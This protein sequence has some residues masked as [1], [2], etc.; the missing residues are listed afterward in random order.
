[1]EPYV[2]VDEVVVDPLMYA[3]GDGV[4]DAGEAVGGDLT[5]TTFCVLTFGEI[6]PPDNGIDARDGAAP[7]DGKFGGGIADSDG[8][9]GNVR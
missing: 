6:D 2:G 3:V 8:G 1:M 4:S 5:M 9:W 7:Q